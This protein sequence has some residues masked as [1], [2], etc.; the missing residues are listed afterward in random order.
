MGVVLTPLG[1]GLVIPKMKAPQPAGQVARRFTRQLPRPGLTDAGSGS[2][3]AGDPGTDMLI[4]RY[5]I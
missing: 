5:C 1:D 4:S 2:G 3:I